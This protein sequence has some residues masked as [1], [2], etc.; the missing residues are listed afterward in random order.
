MVV[1]MILHGHQRALMSMERALEE[2]CTQKK[3]LFP[4]GEPN[5]PSEEEEEVPRINI[6]TDV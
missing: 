6:G 2:N 1:V 4:N 5:L 3:T